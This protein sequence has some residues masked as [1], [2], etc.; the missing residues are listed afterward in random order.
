MR[1]EEWSPLYQAIIDEFGYSR[2]MDARA[3]SILDSLLVNKRI[4]DEGCL[5][6]HIFR[7]V[8][9]CGAASNLQAH[10]DEFGIVGSSIAA[11]N[12]TSVMVANGLLPDVIVTDLDGNVGEQILANA[13]GSVVVVH[14][15]GDNI[16]A[17]K[18]YVPH[19]AGL[20]AG[21]TQGREI[22]AVSNYGGFTDGD[23]AVSL[24][25]HFGASRLRLLGFD[26][27]DPAPKPG[28]EIGVKRR[29]LAWARK[30]IFDHNPDN[31][32]LWIPDPSK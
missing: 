30:L 11:D 6:R 26:F 10:L 27:E 2:Q 32:E 20:I 31:V 17:L 5:S 16:P 14:G 21:T 7:E 22:G 28:R 29:K 25:R 8:T 15:H 4:C 3:A 12:A 1:W 24:A 18:E 23:R 13:E 19:F 9:V